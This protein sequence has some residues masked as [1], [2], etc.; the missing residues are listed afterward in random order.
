MTEPLLIRKRKEFCRSLANTRHEAGITLRE[1]ADVWP[2]S[3]SFVSQLEHGGS[4]VYN[5]DDRRAIKYRN[6]IRD[7]LARRASRLQKEAEEILRKLQP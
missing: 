4:A 6:A 5:D 3:V 1:I 7:A 2:C